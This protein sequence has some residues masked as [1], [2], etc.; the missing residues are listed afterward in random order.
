GVFGGGADDTAF[1]ILPRRFPARTLVLN[2]YVRRLNL[3]GTRHFRLL[4]V[5]FAASVV[6]V[7]VVISTFAAV[8]CGGLFVVFALLF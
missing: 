2:Q 5:V 8:F 3:A 6:V 7:A 4:P 1:R